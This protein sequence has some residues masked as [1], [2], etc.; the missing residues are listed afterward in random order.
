MNNILA[1]C[2]GEITGAAIGFFVAVMM[3]AGKGKG[4]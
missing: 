2:I 4:E 1:L 3:A